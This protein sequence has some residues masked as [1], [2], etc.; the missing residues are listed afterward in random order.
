MTEQELREELEAEYQQKLEEAYGEFEEQMNDAVAGAMAALDDYKNNTESKLVKYRQLSGRLHMLREQKR[1]ADFQ[2]QESVEKILKEMYDLENSNNTFG[3]QACAPMGCC[4]KKMKKA[5]SF[6]KT[7]PFAKMET[8][9]ADD[10]GMDEM[11]PAKAY[12]PKFAA[13]EPAYAYEKSAPCPVLN[14]KFKNVKLLAEESG[15]WTNSVK[16]EAPLW[17]NTCSK[18]MIAKEMNMGDYAGDEECPPS[19]DEFGTKIS[20]K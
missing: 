5:K 19:D 13:D 4:A 17:G 15:P 10:M 3:M 20:D 6:A 11:M 18:P 2:H 8:Y 9:P 7:N 16:S 14:K 1:L 12:S